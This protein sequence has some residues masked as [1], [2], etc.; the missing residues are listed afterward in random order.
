MN[1]G[2][3]LKLLKAICWIGAVT[4]GF[5]TF[6]LLWPNAFI[7]LTGNTALN[8]DFSTRLVM[9]IA[10]SLMAGWTCLLIWTGK[11]PVNR[12]AVFFFTAIPVIAGLIAVMFLGMRNGS[13]STVWIFIKCTLLAFA[14]LYG[15]HTA[16]RIAK[17]GTS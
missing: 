12:K 13:S 4:D 9:G 5:W 3:P 8:T 2:N 1:T 7:L 16:N 11:K 15:Y 14:M 6:V 10:A 17:G